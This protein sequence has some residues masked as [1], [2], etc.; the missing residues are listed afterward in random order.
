[1]QNRAI[2][3]TIASATVFTAFKYYDVAKAM[4]RLPGSFL[5]VGGLANKAFIKS[6]GPELEAIVRDEALKAQVK[7]GPWAI[8]DVERTFQTWRSNGGEII[9]LAPAEAKRYLEV[10]KSVTSSIVASDPKLKGDYEMLLTA[11]KKH[12]Q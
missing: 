10:V 4:T 3:G 2:D 11:A 9:E 6:L 7:V 12:S 5:I 8:K 1:M